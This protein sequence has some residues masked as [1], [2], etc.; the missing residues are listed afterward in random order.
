MKD[1][2]HGR[3]VC[4]QKDEEVV[5]QQLTVSDLTVLLHAAINEWEVGRWFLTEY[6]DGHRERTMAKVWLQ[7]VARQAYDL[8]LEISY[9]H[10][11]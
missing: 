11:S 9:Y 10:L 5:W 3:H 7:W 2:A 6:K 8:H 1:V 4:L